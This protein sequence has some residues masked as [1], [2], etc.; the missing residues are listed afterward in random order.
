MPPAGVT[1]RRISKRLDVPSDATAENVA[2]VDRARSAGY[3]GAG[4][5]AGA[6][7][8]EGK[9]AGEHFVADSGAVH[10]GVQRGAVLVVRLA[11]GFEGGIDTNK[12]EAR[13]APGGGRPPRKFLITRFRGDGLT[14]SADL[15][16]FDD[17]VSSTQSCLERR[18]VSCR[19]RNM[20][21]KR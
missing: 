18:R 2:G 13:P 7:G 11:G 17:R 1:R 14:W 21:E 20:G 12:L 15:L 6:G 19:E 8:V 10:G 3:R 5:G 16:R 9:Q 4:F